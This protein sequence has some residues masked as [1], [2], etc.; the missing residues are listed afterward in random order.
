MCSLTAQ[1]LKDSL[2]G[3]WGPVSKCKS[4]DIGFM[5]TC[6]WGLGSCFEITSQLMLDLCILAAG[7]WGLVSKYN[8]IDIGFM[9]T[10]Y[11]GLGSCFEIQ[12]D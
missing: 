3:V 2:S 5:L 10:S 7:V 12:V 8:L 11:W 4:I 9:F 1:V 6:H